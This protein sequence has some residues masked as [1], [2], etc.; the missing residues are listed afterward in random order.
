MPVSLNATRVSFCAVCLAVFLTALNAP[1]ATAQT[2][3]SHVA[4]LLD[5]S[6]SFRGAADEAYAR[7]VAGDL[8][9]RLPAL[10]MRDVVTI[11]PFGEYGT[12]NLVRE[13]VVSRRFSPEV[14]RNS[15]TSMVAGFPAMVAGQGN[16]TQSAT[17]ILGKLDQIARRMNCAD[18]AGHVFVLSDMQE[19]GQAMNL[20]ARPMFEDCES[21]TIIGLQG[22]SPAQTEVLADFWMRWCTAAGFARCDWLS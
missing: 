20:P 22:Q 2:Q 7:R 3:S 12:R 16:G 8:A 9:A 17:N 19:T 21:L 5:A 15:V 18:K 4:V 13:A 14:A 11:Q 6:G 10:Q 1:V